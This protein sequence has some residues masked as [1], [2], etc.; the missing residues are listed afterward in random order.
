MNIFSFDDTS[1]FKIKR[2]PDQNNLFNLFQKNL[3]VVAGIPLNVYV[4]PREFEMRLDR[5]SN[6]IYGSPNYVEELMALNDIINPYSVKEGQ[7]IYFCEEGNLQYLYTKDDLSTESEKKRQQLIKS[8]QPNRSNQSIPSNQNLPLTI[9]PSNLNQITV[10][11]DNN[12]KIIN[13][14]E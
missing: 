1:N 7:Y 8:S 10:G 5:I 4:V 13:S 12:V 9:K 3:M 6:F 2:D 14:F 11:A